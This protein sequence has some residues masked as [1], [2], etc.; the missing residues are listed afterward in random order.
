LDLSVGFGRKEF[1]DRVADLFDVRT[2]APVTVFAGLH[3]N[4]INSIHW[5]P[6]H[7]FR[8]TTASFGVET[9]KQHFAV[10]GVWL[11]GRGRHHD[12]NGGYSEAGQSAV[13]GVVSVSSCDSSLLG[14][15]KGLL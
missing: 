3:D 4:A 2:P 1:L 12:Q 9:L 8:F 13:R 14:R 15:A 11:T 10:S 7:P 5:D 6:L